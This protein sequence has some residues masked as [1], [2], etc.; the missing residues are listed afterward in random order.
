MV[1]TSTPVATTPPIHR[2]GNTLYFEADDGTNGHELW[3]SDGTASGTEM[4]VNIRPGNTNELQYHFYNGIV[5]INNSVYFTANDGT[6]GY[7]LWTL[8][9][10]SGSGGMT[11]VTGATCSISPSFQL[12][13]PLTTHVHHQRYTNG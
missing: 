6:N 3:K 5:G 4:V 2:R 1:K 9:G 13:C 10:G 8:S 12:V 7:E 11:N